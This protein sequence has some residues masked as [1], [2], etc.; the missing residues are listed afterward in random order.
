[1]HAN[2]ANLIIWSEAFAARMERKFLEDQEKNSEITLSQWRERGWH[3][4]L[5]E[6]FASL[7]DYWL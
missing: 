6:Q 3:R 5:V 4:H 1:M 2:E 7:F